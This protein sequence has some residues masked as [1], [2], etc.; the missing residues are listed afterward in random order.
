MSRRLIWVLWIALAA[1]W[2]GT[3][4][5][6]ALVRPD[7]GR[8]AEIPREMAASGD[9]V[10]PRLNE[11]KYFEKPALQYWATAAGYKVFG[12]S[13]WTARLWPALT[14]FLSVLL[15]WWTGRRLWGPVAGHLAA[16]I[17]ASSLLFVVLGHLITLDMGL[18]FFLQVAWTAF[19]FAQ[20]DERSSSRRW[21]LL[22]WGALAL[23]VLSKGLVAL[24]LVGAA[25]VGYTLLNRDLS[26]WRRLAPLRGL[27]LFLLVAA[28]WF[29]AVSLANPEFPQFFFIHEHFERFLS[30]V[31][32][33]NEPGWY[34]LA[35]YALGAL[36][37]SLLLVHTLLKSWSQGVGGR[38]SAD[39]FLLVWIIATF[40]FFSVSGSKMAPYILPIFP[41]LALLGGHNIASLSRRAW[42]IHLAL[43]AALAVAALAT[44][45]RVLRLAGDSYSLEM[46]QGV[47]NWLTGA[48]AISLAS[49]VAAMLLAWAQHKVAA[50]AILAV[51]G[52]LSTSAGLLG[53]DHLSP[54]SSTRGLAVQAQPRLK[55]GVPFYSVDYYEQTLPFYLKRTL[56]MVA[57][58]NELSFGIEQEPH[59][60]IPTI[61]E[62]TLRWHHDRDAFAVMTLDVFERLATAGLPMTEIARNRRYVIVEK[63][64]AP[65]ALPVTA[66]VT[67][68]TT[69]PAAAR[70]TVPASA[71]AAHGPGMS[72]NSRVATGETP[73]AEKAAS[74]NH[75]SDGAP[76]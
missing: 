35:V 21:M 36:P 76:H 53:H 72:G 5:Q 58:E 61:D 12:Q 69:A 55:P 40:A 41:A 8:Y 49:I 23:A 60:W 64:A 29:V 24:V 33:R 45:P 75:A 62:F 39:R 1:V 59:K 31:H 3:L 27:A 22:A 63:P 9:W 66:T 56:T 26:P 16:A 48:A 42:L 65:V 17:L 71:P 74:L 11:F 7:E 57:T 54:Y 10:T 52:L 51:G 38:F 30:T 32:R 43:L 19:L 2:F 46:L 67:V 50:A 47:L 18:S 37:W 15:A 68:S 70:A 14:G 34:F 44:A 25:L 73:P 28:P 20:N 13:E 6:R 4:D